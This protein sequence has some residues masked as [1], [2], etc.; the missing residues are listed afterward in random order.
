M[1]YYNCSLA[2]VKQN[3]TEPPRCRSEKECKGPLDLPECYGRRH[4]VAALLGLWN[5]SGKGLPTM[6]PQYSPMITKSSKKAD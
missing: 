5:A 2:S 1:P 4:R 3:R 6:T